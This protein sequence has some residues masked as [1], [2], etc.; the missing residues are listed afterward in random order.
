MSKDVI[1]KPHQKKR[2]F[3]GLHID[4]K[5]TPYILLG[6]IFGL[7]FLCWFLVGNFLSDWTSRGQFDDMF[8][9][10]NALFSGLAFA[11]IIYT[12][13]LQREELEEQRK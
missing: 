1:S 12:I 10:V 6:F 2:T 8:G 9:T 3:F 4:D 13:L 5:K 7:W 11:G